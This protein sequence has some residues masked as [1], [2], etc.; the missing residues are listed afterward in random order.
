MVNATVVA[1]PVPMIAFEAGW[2]AA[3]L[4]R[5]SLTMDAL[6]SES[7]V[8]PPIVRRAYH[9]QQ[10]SVRIAIKSL[11]AIQQAHARNVREYS[12][13]SQRR[14]HWARRL[15][16]RAWLVELPPEAFVLDLTG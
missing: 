3:L 10:V 7:G 1:N 11:E 13:A 12:N 14:R 5:E 2:F 16:E 6:S 4:R 9:G 8:S 15:R